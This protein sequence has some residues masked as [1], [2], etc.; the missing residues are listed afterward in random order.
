MLHDSA[1]KDQQIGFYSSSERISA[2]ERQDKLKEASD[3]YLHDK[4]SDDEL[5]KAEEELG[6][7]YRRAT[8]G[9]TSVLGELSELLKRLF[10]LQRQ[11]FK[12]SNTEDKR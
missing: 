5:Q 11:T 9:I 3:K 2:Q 8:Y 4:I 6:I 10:G 12:T 7:N 1:S